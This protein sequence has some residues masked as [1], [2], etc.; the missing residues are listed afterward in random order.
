MYELGHSFGSSHTHDSDHYAPLVNTCSQR[1]S[2]KLLSDGSATLMSTCQHCPDGYRNFLYTFGGKYL[3][4]GPRTDADNY[5]DTPALADLGAVSVDS[6]R[7]SAWMY[8][9]ITS[10][11]CAAIADPVPPLTPPA[12]TGSPTEPPT[13]EPT[14]AL[15]K[16]PTAPPTNIPTEA[17]TKGPTK[18]PTL[19][20]T[21]APTNKPTDAPTPAPIKN[22]MSSPT[23][24][25]QQS[26]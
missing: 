14:N 9:H 18:E 13:K 21:E 7:A 10:R 19:A 4:S 26:Q 2:G 5:V 15:T 8:S 25:P 20:P 17:S 23:K 6:R 11:G 12:A 1:C 24:N 3:G 22:P 16:G